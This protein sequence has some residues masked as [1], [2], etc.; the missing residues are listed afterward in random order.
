MGWWQDDPNAPGFH[1]EDNLDDPT[2]PSDEN[3]ENFLFY[4][5]AL[6][7]R[8]AMAPIRFIAAIVS[9]K[10]VDDELAKRGVLDGEEGLEQTEELFNEYGRRIFIER[11][12]K[13]R[14]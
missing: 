1:V 11:G 13:R 9:A 8:A 6:P 4:V 12:R 3:G 14:R 7:F 5:I 10:R 2:F